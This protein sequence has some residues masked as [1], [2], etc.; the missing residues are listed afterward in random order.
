[1]KRAC[2]HARS[3][4]N[5]VA[6]LDQDFRAARHPHIHARTE[7]HQSDPF[8]ALHDV[9]AL[10]PAHYPPRD[11]SGNLF[12]DYFSCCCRKRNNV[13]LILE[14]R[15]R[16]HGR[17]KF[18]GAVVHGGNRAGFWRSIDVHVPYRQENADT[19]AR[20]PGIVFFGNHHNAAIRR[21]YQGS[22]FGRN[23]ALRIAEKI[24]NEGSE[25]DQDNRHNDP[26]EEKCRNS[27]GERGHPEVIALFNHVP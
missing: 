11:Q 19:L 18:T 16:T 25:K 2:Q 1:M 13:L 21:R 22:W 27:Q 17:Q 26:M 5:V 4:F 8:A 12:E 3:A 20:P 7:A 23:S 10:L 14:R 9:S 24:E 15:A 6:G